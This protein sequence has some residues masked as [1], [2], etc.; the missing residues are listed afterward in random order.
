MAGF[1]GGNGTGWYPLPYSGHGRIWK[2]GYF[3]NVLTPGRWVHR[4]D[5]AIIPAGCTNAST[6]SMITA[7]PWGP[8]QGGVAINVSGP[9]LRPKDAVKNKIVAHF[10]KGWISEFREL[11]G[12]LQTVESSA[13]PVHHADLP[14]DGHGDDPDESRRRSQLPL[15]WEVLRRGS[16]QSPSCRE[17]EGRRGEGPE[18]LG[19]PH[20]RNPLHGLAILESDVESEC[21]RRHQPLGLLGGR[22]SLPFR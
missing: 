17:A 7:P 16:T 4:V 5:E 21:S 20:P 6:G 1:N 8:M 18:P 14:Q 10:A 15:H 22:R 9:C 13:S 2:L 3:S 19:P 11:G 12:G